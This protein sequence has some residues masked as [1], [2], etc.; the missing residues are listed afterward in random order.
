MG[1][2]IFFIRE[3]FRAL[4]RN[5]APSMAAIVT[6]VVTVILLGVLIPIFQATQSK[7]SEVRSQ[8]Q[9]RVYIYDDAT[10]GEVGSL[11]R[12]LRAVPHV[13]SVHYL[14]KADAL[15]EFKRDFDQE[16]RDVLAELHSNPL[17]AN[18]IVKP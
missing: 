16:H 11:R 2:L 1:R 14:S 8:L 12:E 9:L 13:K 7:S 10:K 5:A 18:F 17:P 4:R 3:A 6:T 15:A